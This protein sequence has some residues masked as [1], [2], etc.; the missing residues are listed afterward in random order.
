MSEEN[1]SNQ[2]H[3]NEAIAEENQAYTQT[4]L[5]YLMNRV[6]QLNAELRQA[7]EKIAELEKE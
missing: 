7:K 3:L 6:V 1:D 2:K 4:Q 5:N